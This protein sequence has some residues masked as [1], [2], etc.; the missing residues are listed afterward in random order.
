MRFAKALAGCAGSV[1]VALSCTMPMGCGLGATSSTAPAP[2]KE[3]ETIASA[4]PQGVTLETPVV[5]DPLYGAE[6]KTVGDALA[7]LMAYTRDGKLYDGGMGREIRF[8]P[9]GGGGGKSAPKHVDKKGKK[10]A[11]SYTTIKLAQ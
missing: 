7:S 11:T 4:L 1:L 3:K 5:A 2:L 9:A 8:E 10:G 6:S